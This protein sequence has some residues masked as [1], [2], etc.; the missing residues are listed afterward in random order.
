MSVRTFMRRYRD[1]K[2]AARRPLVDIATTW[3]ERCGVS[4]AFVDGEVRFQNMIVDRADAA[5]FTPLAFSWAKDHARVYSYGSVVDGAEPKSFT[6]LDAAYGADANRVFGGRS[7]LEADVATFRTL[8]GG[9]GADKRS[10]FCAELRI[11]FIACWTIETADPET[12]ISLAHGWAVDKAHAYCAGFVNAEADPKRLTPLTRW[13]ATDGTHVLTHSRILPEAD[14]ATFRALDE[15]YG[16][17]ATR[18]YHGELIARVVKHANRASFRAIGGEFGVD[19]QYAFWESEIIAGIA[20]DELRAISKSFA[21]T[22]DQ[23]LYFYSGIHGSRKITDDVWGTRPIV[24]AGADSATFRDTGELYGADAQSAYYHSAKLD[25]RGDARRF[26]TI[27]H[28]L[29]RDDVAVY[30]EAEVVEGADPATFR[31]IAPATVARDREHW[32]LYDPYGDYRRI[33]AIDAA[34]ARRI[35][36]GE[37]QIESYSDDEY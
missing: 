36:D 28:C 1:L 19:D 18:V 32:Y 11:G 16:V 33:E 22:N 21:C 14:P 9:Y 29:A 23:V 35:L 30:F 5:T 6:P 20:P 2:R 26:E 31:I 10:V 4:Y 3:R 15:H 7:A 13:L 34:R 27:G 17:D 24:L 37:E 8:G 25:L 12:F